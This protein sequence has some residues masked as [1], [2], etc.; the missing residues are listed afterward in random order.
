MLRLE[1]F[2]S[3]APRKTGFDGV[4]INLANYPGAYSRF[5][6]LAGRE[7]KN[8]FGLS[9]KDYLDAVVTG[10]HVMSAV[11]ER[12]GDGPDGGKADFI[13]KTINDFRALAKKQLLEEYPA[14]KVDVAAK[15]ERYSRRC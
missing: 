1:A 6:E 11:Y 2:V 10:K 8:T 13:R 12:L 7:V 3:A 5:V 15:S 4:T 14:I 9:A